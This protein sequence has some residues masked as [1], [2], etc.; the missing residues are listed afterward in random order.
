M[1]ALD[2][3][4]DRCVS[5]N[6]I[7][8]VAS[9]IVSM[10]SDNILWLAVGMWVNSAT[11]NPA[12]ASV[13]MLIFGAGLLFGPLGGVVVD[14]ARR[15]PIVLVTNAVCVLAVLLLLRV[16]GPH[17]LTLV[18]VVMFV[19]GVS[20]AILGP[21]HGALLQTIASPDRLRGVVSAIQ[22]VRPTVRIL[23]PLVGAYLYSFGGLPL[24]V[25]VCVA[26]FVADSAILAS[27]RIH[28]PPPARASNN[29]I[30]EL[31]A[32]TFHIASN[33]SLRVATGYVACVMFAFG[34][35][36]S[37]LFAVATDSFGD[38]NRVIGILNTVQGLGAI[39]AGYCAHRLLKKTPD[40]LLIL[41]SVALASCALLL[42]SVP[43]RSL[44]ICGIAMTGAAG[45]LVNVGAAALFLR[46]TH[47]SIVGRTD[48]SLFFTLC[49]FQF[50]AL[51]IG[52]ACVAAQR[53]DVAMWV[54]SGILL[55]I[56]THGTVRHVVDTGTRRHL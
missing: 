7:R 34:I 8:Y 54:T 46:Q 36:R 37:A 30:M 5:V 1:R 32:G 48:A 27:L 39:I 55:A 9:Q 14:R 52:A 42:Q 35:S 38:A 2:S 28:E 10:V 11:G 6:L 40:G 24:V 4:A 18:Y 21:A 45:T 47:H 49:L 23:A 53:Y 31:S 43:S 26:G 41:L 25:G 16:H 3:P 56:F 33:R 44:A 20:N 51:G 12:S 22:V 13:I 15:R 50:A 19:Y 29:F 17:Q